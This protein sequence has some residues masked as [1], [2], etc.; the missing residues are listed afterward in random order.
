MNGG[1]TYK[2]MEDRKRKAAAFDEALAYLD[3]RASTDEGVHV[4]RILRKAE[5]A[6]KRREK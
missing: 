6:A 1:V 5:A 3:G 2:D 4:R